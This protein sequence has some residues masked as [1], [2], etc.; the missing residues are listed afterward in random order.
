MRAV[1]G[2]TLDPPQTRRRTR[3]WHVAT[4][5]A[6]LSAA[7]I[8]TVD[9]PVLHTTP[10]PHPVRASQHEVALKSTPVRTLRAT[11]PRAANATPDP[12]ATATAAAIAPPQDVPHGVAVVGVTWA[13]SAVSAGDQFQIRTLTGGVWGQWETLDRDESHGPD[14]TGVDA[15]EGRQAEEGTQPYVVTGADK[16]E[17]R[18]LSS[19][20]TAPTA[21]QVQVIDPG[22]STADDTISAPAPGQAAAAA[23][24]PTIYTRAQWGADESLR[25]AAPDYGQTQVAFVHHTDSA[26]NYTAAQVPAIIRGIYAYHVKSQGWNDIGYNF[27]VDR[28][29]RIWEGRYGGMDKAVI[30]A[31]TLNYNSWSFGVSAIGNFV[32]ATPPASM[33][34]GIERVIAWKLSI[35]GLPA[36]GTVYAKDKWFNRISGHRDAFQTTCPGQA[37]YSRLPQIRSAVASLEGS[38]RRA[39]LSHDV[40]RNGAPDLVSYGAG[41]PVSMLPAAAPSPVGAGIRI[42]TAWGGLRNISISPDLSSDGHPD[43]L[44]QDPAKGTLRVYEG[45][46]TGRFAG[47]IVGGNG[48]NGINRIIPAGDRDGDGRNDFYGTT[49]AG[50]LILYSGDG[51][52]W[53]LRKTVV[54]VGWQDMSSIV[55]VNDLDGDGVKD[56]YAVRRSDGALFSFSGRPN[57]ALTNKVQRGSG[58]GGFTAV[59][60]GDLD[61]DGRPDLVARASDGTMRTYY[62]TGGAGLGRNQRWGSSWGPLTNLSTGADFNG[63]GTPDVLAVNPTTGGT[64]MMYPG[65]GQRDYS[66]Q[67]VAQG[68]PADT[69]L[70]RVVGDV[71]GDGHADAIA[72]V[73]STDQLLFLRGQSGTRFAAP[74]VIGAGWEGF[75][76]IE[77]AGDLNYDGVPDLMARTSTGDLW[78]YPMKRSGGFGSRMKLGTGWNSLLSFTGVGAFN[79]DGNADVVALRASDHSLVLYRGSGPTP[80][81]DSTVLASRQ[82]DLAQVVGSGD[83]NGDGKPDLVARGNNGTLWLYTGNGTGGLSGSRQPLRGGEGTTHVIG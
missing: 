2:E 80:L 3:L 20:G 16:F 50:Q 61:G 1:P 58:W 18:A 14:V 74:V 79:A 22:T 55:P 10:K 53:I 77:A 78:L 9:L 33:V 76:A 35:A 75:T 63:D 4:L 6:A 15:A 47:T 67:P 8:I 27:L 72:R 70:V 5:A 23:G 29:G 51:H 13:G 57:G 17:V 59:I 68:L 21:A 36:T 24:R 37:L 34:S 32:S 39:T 69:D 64:L 43:V 73:R 81:L 65:S 62:G 28:F 60:G 49:P 19:D 83:Y 30:G 25:R 48:W 41:G 42:G 31:H 46:G 26:N 7:P 82:T 52:G 12:A 38:I 54:G 44:A 71:D 56:V 40:T 11:G 45:T 66:A